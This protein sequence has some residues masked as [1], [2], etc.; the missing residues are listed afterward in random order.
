MSFQG[1]NWLW[2]L[3]TISVLLVYLITMLVSN[4]TLAFGQ[5]RIGLSTSL[6]GGLALT[7]KSLIEGYGLWANDVNRR[8]GLAGRKVQ[9]IIYDDDGILERGVTNLV[10]LVEM[11]KVHILFGPSSSAVL[12]ASRI[13][14]EKNRVPVIAASPVSKL[15]G[16]DFHYLFQGAIASDSEIDILIEFWVGLGLPL[17]DI[18][19]LA[20]S[21]PYH[22]ALSH[23]LSKEVVKYD[24]LVV[25][26]GEVHPGKRDFAA[27]IWRIRETT[28][29]IFF[30]ALNP[31]QALSVAR[32][33]SEAGLKAEMNVF[34]SDLSGFI[35]NF[36]KAVPSRTLGL[37]NWEPSLNT[38]GNQEFV[39]KF[40]RRYGRLPSPLSAQAWSNGQVLKEVVAKVGSVDRELIRK[41]LS[42]F[43]IAT[44]LGRYKL[45]EHR[46]QIGYKPLIVQWLEGKKEIVYPVKVSTKK[47]ILHRY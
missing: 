46:R 25:Y 41:G 33:F 22:R 17:R 13:I 16:K 15:Y 9:L 26:Q 10:K 29:D 44:I 21:D 34:S 38:P 20:T 28:P 30:G 19:V 3:Q 2:A 8:G 7:G 40:K 39:E 37:S 14:S 12:M 11:D 5:I 47:L 23:R 1:R 27:S 36:Q 18:A 6:S 42:R 4:H 24:M 45:D 32:M 31:Q 35:E 43:E